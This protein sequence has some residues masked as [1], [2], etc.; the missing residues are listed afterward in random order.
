MKIILKGGNVYRGDRFTASD[1]LIDG[2]R[3]VSI[4]D[5]IDNI[6]VDKVISCD[7]FFV[8]PGFI[9]VHVHLR[10][11][12]F[13]YKGT[14]K[15]ETEAAAAGGYTAVLAMPNVVPAPSDL[16][17]LEV[18]EQI[19]RKDAA[20]K[21]IPYGTI[22]KEQSGRGSLSAMDEI[23]G[24]VASFSDDGKGV[25]DEA[26]MRQAMIKAAALDRVITAHCENEAYPAKDA[27]SEWTEAVRDIQLTEET[28][29]ALHICHVSSAR[30][31]EAV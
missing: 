19:I 29:A 4:A 11:P 7:S 16:S 15:T 27:R 9:D 26:L 12:G 2:G 5:N 8:C 1:I 23:A 24:R 6:S 14:V 30:T 25:Q 10:E 31:L 18:M 21:V 22:T 28:G 17:S 20:I 3:V 13:S